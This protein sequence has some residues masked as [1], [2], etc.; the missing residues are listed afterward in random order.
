LSLAVE[1]LGILLEKKGLPKI[2]QE[3]YRGRFRFPLE[4]FYNDMGLVGG[5]DSFEKIAF[6][7][8]NHYDKN[9]SNLNL[10]PGVVEILKNSS[11]SHSILS[12]APEVHLHEI[13]KKF[14]IHSHFENIFGL[15]H[16]FGDSKIQRGHELLKKIK[17]KRDEIIL[18]GDTDHDLE[19]GKALGVSV[20]LV[21]DGHQ[22][23]DR[24]RK[25]H[26]KVIRTRYV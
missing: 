19:V 7:F 21:A 26:G 2:S 4:D 9:I 22:S 8:I 11:F 13:T 14:G 25:A 6:E 16:I 20:L 17:H 18:I 5:L 1:G 24:L 15:S 10:F 23:Y 3:E 12:A